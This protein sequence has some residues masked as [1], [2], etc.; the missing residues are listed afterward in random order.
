[1]ECTERGY[2]H[3]FLMFKAA[4][5][6]IDQLGLSLTARVY[7]ESSGVDYIAYTVL[8]LGLMSLVRD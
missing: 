5:I 2:D 7:L 1:M 4:R 6:L 8:L 3:G